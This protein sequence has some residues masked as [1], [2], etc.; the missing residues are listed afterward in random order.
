MHCNQRIL[1]ISKEKYVIGLI[2]G[3]C[4]ANHLPLEILPEDKEVLLSP[5]SKKFQ[6]ILIDSSQSEVPLNQ[7]KYKTIVKA[8]RVHHIP[9]CAIINESKTTADK[10]ETNEWVEC[11]F[12]TP[13]LEHLDDFFR[14][15]FHY[16]PHPFPDRR[17]QERR[18]AVDRRNYSD[19]R[20]NN[21]ATLPLS[22]QKTANALNSE[23]NEQ[24]SRLIPFKINTSCQSVSFKGIDLEL[25]GKEFKLFCFLATDTNRVFSSDEIIHHLWPDGY[26]AT[27]SDLYQYMHLLRK[28]VEEDPDKPKWIITIK[29]VGY[30]LNISPNTSE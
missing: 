13:I 30:K 12:K 10:T 21:T 4:V 20:C 6:L 26:R 9:V 14:I 8:S 27:K 7:S 15:H 25:T 24:D 5:E 23:I 22:T 2:E 28:K 1:L 11:F 3:Y 17:H 18:L 29:R 19:R 16:K